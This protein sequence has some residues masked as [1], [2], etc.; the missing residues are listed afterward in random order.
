MP[1][2]SNVYELIALLVMAAFQVYTRWEVGRL[3]KKQDVANAVLETNR[4]HL[5]RVL[6]RSTALVASKDVHRADVV[7][8]VEVALKVAYFQ[9]K[10]DAGTAE[11]YP[12]ARVIAA[13]EQLATIAMQAVKNGNGHGPGGPGPRPDQTPAV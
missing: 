4:S 3:A 13:A 2:V 12:E 7:G 11:P 5:L 8:A 9:G 6:D 1:S 10:A